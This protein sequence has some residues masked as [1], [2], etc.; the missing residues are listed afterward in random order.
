MAEFRT[1]AEMFPLVEAYLERNQTKTAFCAAHGISESV[2]G[3]WRSKYRRE[4]A[5]ESGAFVEI[6]PPA[7]AA[8]HALMELVYPHGVRL[9]LFAM[10][11]AADLERLVGF[12]RRLA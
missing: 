6:T 10:P 2:L 5:P 7:A 11:A 8:E 3:Y 12:G 4:N 1:R 9:R